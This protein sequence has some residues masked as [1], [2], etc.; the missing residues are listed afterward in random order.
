V[1]ILAAAKELAG[2]GEVAALDANGLP[3]DEGIGNLLAGRF[4][5]AVESGPRD[6]HP[7][8]ALFL[9]QPF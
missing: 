7:L 6:A 3:I 1:A 2:Q 9:L 4:Q 8:G 5:H